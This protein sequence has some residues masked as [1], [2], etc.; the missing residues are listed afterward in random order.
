MGKYFVIICLYVLLMMIQQK[1]CFDETSMTPQYWERISNTCISLTVSIWSVVLRNYEK[2]GHL[3]HISCVYVYNHCRVPQS[4]PGTLDRQI[5]SANKSPVLYWLTNHRADRRFTSVPQSFVQ[6]ND[7]QYF[8]WCSFSCN[9]RFWDSTMHLNISPN[10]IK[11]Y[12]RS[13]IQT[14]SDLMDLN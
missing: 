14:V 1:S 6:L 3:R 13:P 4:G 11:D 7:L 5:L 2:H 8:H 12:Q 10:S 9:K